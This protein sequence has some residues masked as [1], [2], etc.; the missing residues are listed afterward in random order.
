MGRLDRDLAKV[1]LFELWPLALQTRIARAPEVTVRGHRR[2]TIRPCPESPWPDLHRV[3][4]DRWMLTLELP[5]L[6]RPVAC[7]GL[8][9]CSAAQPLSE[10]SA[11]PV[12]VGHAP[13][14]VACAQGHRFPAA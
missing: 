3:C 12:P 4:A 2:D 11:R 9:W 5:K 6:S 1:Q 13:Q 7:T 10:M 14:M 8:S